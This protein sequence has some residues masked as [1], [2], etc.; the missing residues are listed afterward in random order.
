MEESFLRQQLLE[1]IPAFMARVAPGALLRTHLAEDPLP[2]SFR[3]GSLLSLGKA[4][5][6]MAETLA[7]L[8]SIS[9]RNTLS[10]LPEGY[11][12]PPASFPVQEGAHPLPDPRSLE[13]FHKI[14]AFIATIPKDD[15]VVVA[16][17]GG[18][19]SLV[20]APIPPVT[21]EDKIRVTRS[22][23]EAGAPIATINALRLHL[24]K[25]K[26]GG[27][28]QMLSPHPH[29]TFVL[30]DIPGPGAPLVGS[31]PMVAIPRNG[32]QILEEINLFLSPE[33]IP[34]TVRQL[35]EALPPQNLSPKTFPESP[36]RVV[37]SS[38]SLIE[39]LTDTL[40]K[41]SEISPLPLH[42]LTTEL[43]GEAREAGR[44]LASI[45]SWGSQRAEARHQGS[46]WAA[47]GETTVTL[48]GTPSGKGGRTLELAL[49]L[50]LSLTPVPALVLS[51]ASDGFDGNS[52]AAGALIPTSFFSSS[53]RCIE[54]E[55]ALRSH[56]SG[57]FLGRHGLTMKTGPSGTN[58]ND[59][60]M[61]IVFPASLS[62]RSGS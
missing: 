52:G 43:R 2:S 26:G 20:A 28:D 19:S 4:A 48:T 13:A 11:P 10:I 44:V 54:G 46:V 6:A 31:S 62:Q 7:D 50:A 29:L 58:V 49:A 36:L 56:D 45:I 35:L 15:S 34:P 40:M 5:G 27:L 57:G 39:A 1:A 23:M 47:S 42:S 9:P 59:L 37:G 33:I 16:L 17:S 8:L 53:R 24:S 61:V 32:P 18:S 41:I 3:P 55:L 25:F 21:L 51:L 30:S 12:R 60:L 22:L 38:A 14:Q